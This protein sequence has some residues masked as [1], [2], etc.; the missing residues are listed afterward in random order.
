MRN[1]RTILVTVAVLACVLLLLVGLNIYFGIDD[2]YAQWGAADMVIDY[3][4]SHGGEWPT[5]WE[6][7]VPA[8]NAGGG[9]V[10]GWSFAQFRR[11]VP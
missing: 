2:A 11:R 5:N 9:R 1:L 8:F 4:E 7:L 10:G 3:L 6:A